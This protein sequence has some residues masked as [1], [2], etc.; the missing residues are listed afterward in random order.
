MMTPRT[1]KRMKV[2][3]P[4]ITGSWK[5]SMASNEKRNTVREAKRPTI[6]WFVVFSVLIGILQ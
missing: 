5:D 4:D 2:I 1:G 3:Y 6:G